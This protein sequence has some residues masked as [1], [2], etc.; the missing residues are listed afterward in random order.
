[1][2]CNQNRSSTDKVPTEHEG[3]NTKRQNQEP[4]HKQDL[5]AQKGVKLRHSGINICYIWMTT[6]FF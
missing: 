6:V 1:M 5:K 4:L 3:S 2:R